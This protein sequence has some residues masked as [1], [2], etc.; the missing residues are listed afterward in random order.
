MRPAP[1]GT[2]NVRIRPF[3]REDYPAMAAVQSA[4]GHQRPRTAEVL[5]FGDEH[6]D[7][8]CLAARWVAEQ[9]GEVVGWAGYDQLVWMYDPRKFV[10]S[11]FVHPARQGRGIGAL[12]YKTVTGALAPYDPA[13]L[14]VLEVRADQEQSVGFLVARGF[15]EAMRTWVL[16]LAL[17]SFDPAPFAT[18]GILDAHHLEIRTMAELASDPDLDRKLYLLVNAVH[19]D[20]PTPGENTPLT[21]EHFVENM[22]ATPELEPERIFVAVSRSDGAYVGLSILWSIPGSDNLRGGITG[23]ARP[24]RRQGVAL[25]LKL[26]A[27]AYARAHGYAAVETMNAADNTAI[28]ALNE[29]LGFVKQFALIDFQN[30]LTDDC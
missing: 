25:A 1:A 7:A 3:A 14:Y 26:H 30:D 22:L 27:I 2:S 28:L 12:L 11:G 10:L 19:E 20:V 8:R 23:V 21:Y 18:A 15:R 17:A 5:Q 9:N 13:A 4:A 24:Y 16:H 6:R 29:R